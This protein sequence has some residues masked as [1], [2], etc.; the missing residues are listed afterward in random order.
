MSALHDPI[1]K[2]MCVCA[3]AHMYV[4]L[5]MYV[6]GKIE[7]TLQVQKHHQR[8]SFDQL[9]QTPVNELNESL[10]E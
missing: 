1:D 7:V 5:C 10:V 8:S 3:R 6:F 4:R 9:H 2:I